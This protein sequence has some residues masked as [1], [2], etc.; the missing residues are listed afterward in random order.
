MEAY[1]SNPVILTGSFWWPVPILKLSIYIP[2]A[3][4]LISMRRGPL[5]PPPEIPRLS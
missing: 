4:H 5:S 3:S 2:S 1:S